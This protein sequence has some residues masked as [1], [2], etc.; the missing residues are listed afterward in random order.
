M[1]S[2]ENVERSPAEEARYHGNAA[3]KHYAT[4]KVIFDQLANG[5]FEGA[6]VIEA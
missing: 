5:R 4:L 6:W 1:I 2:R 3:I